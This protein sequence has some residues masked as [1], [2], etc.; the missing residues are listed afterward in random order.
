MFE[1]SGGRNQHRAIR[2]ATGSSSQDLPGGSEEHGGTISF[3]S[4]LYFV[5]GEVRRHFNGS[6]HVEFVGIGQIFTFQRFLLDYEVD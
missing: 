6:D 1:K 2:P 5:V 3:H 4:P